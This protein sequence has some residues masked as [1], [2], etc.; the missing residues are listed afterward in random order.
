MEMRQDSFET[1]EKEK[2]KILGEYSE[3][4]T[5][6]FEALEEQFEK[7]RKKIRAQRED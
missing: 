5:Q 4:L 7:D 1:L 2:R 6:Q 3:K